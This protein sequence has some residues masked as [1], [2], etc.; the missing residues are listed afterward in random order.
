MKERIRLALANELNTQDGASWHANAT[1][2]PEK[3]QAELSQKVLVCHR[4]KP[5]LC[6]GNIFTMP[7]ARADANTRMEPTVAY[8]GAFYGFEMRMRV[9][10]RPH[11]QHHS[12]SKKLAAKGQWRQLHDRF[13]L[14][15]IQLAGRECSMRLQSHRPQTVLVG[16]LSQSQLRHSHLPCLLV[17]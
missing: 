10:L 15:K 7:F 14:R 13:T 2:W 3:S 5:H 17:M 16:K 6:G 9:R 1:S 4:E 11:C 12:L 8:S